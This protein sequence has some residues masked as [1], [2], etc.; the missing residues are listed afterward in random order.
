MGIWSSFWKKKGKRDSLSEDTRKHV[1]EREKALPCTWQV[2]DV[3]SLPIYPKGFKVLGIKS[4]GMGH[5]YICQWTS[6]G[7]LVALKTFH[8]RLFENKEAIDRFRW[9]AEVWIRLGEHKNIVKAEGVSESSG[10]VFVVIEYVAGDTHYGNDLSGWIRGR[11]ID[12]PLSLDFAVQ[13]CSGMIYAHKIF[14]EMKKAFVHRDIKPGNIMVTGDKIVKITDFGL[15]KAF[16]QIKADIGDERT[17]DDMHQKGF[18]LTKMGSILGTPAYMAPEQW[19]GE[20]VDHRADIYGFACVLYEMLTGQPPFMC[21]SWHEFKAHHLKIKPKAIPNVPSE[22]NALV[23]Q[24]LE[25]ERDKRYPDFETLR[26]GLINVIK[27]YYPKTTGDI[28]GKI[29]NNDSQDT[30]GGLLRK[31][32]GLKELGLNNEAIECYKK[33]A[34]LALN[35]AL[36]PEYRSQSVWLAYSLLGNCYKDLGQYSKAIKYFNEA[37]GINPTDAKDH[38]QLAQCHEN[39][40]QYQEAIKIWQKYFEIATNDP[41]EEEHW[42][43]KA[44]QQ[45]QDLKR[46]LSGKRR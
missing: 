35:S 39:L 9:E 15:V 43:P 26:R 10:Y 3:I 1:A 23:V 27:V 41:Y 31:G 36:S 37:V 21:E 40:G 34:E 38:Y 13:F 30:V 42:M 12:V 44:H 45:V 8:R 32:F 46:K 19:L 16:S 18:G 33:A 24:C 4:G 14:L 5:V 28:L 6:Q 17:E 11:G 25:K 22:L 20:D 2:G 7:K 29:E